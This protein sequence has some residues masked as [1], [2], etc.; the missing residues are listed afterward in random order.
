MQKK[1]T[2]STK[3]I[4]LQNFKLAQKARNKYEKYNLGGYIQLFPR[5]ETDKYN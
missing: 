2:V 4:K 5:K 1:N 3:E